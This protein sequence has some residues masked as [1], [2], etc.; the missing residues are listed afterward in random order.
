MPFIEQWRRNVIAQQGLEGLEAVVPGDRCYV[1]Y[2]HFVDEWN[3]EP[4]WATVHRLLMEMNNIFFPTDDEEVAAA[5]AWQ[6]FFNIHVM[7]YE[8]LKRAENGDI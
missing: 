1:H 4:R 7:P 5:L 2:K 6:V 8:L 3:N